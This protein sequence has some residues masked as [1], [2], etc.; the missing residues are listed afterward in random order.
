M[1]GAVLIVATHFGVGGVLDDIRMVRHPLVHTLLILEDITAWDASGG[2]LTKPAEP[3]VLEGSKLAIHGSP[4]TFVDAL[5]HG[6][7]VEVVVHLVGSTFVVLRA[8]AI[9]ED[10]VLGG[11]SCVSTLR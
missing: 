11:T 3:G 6:A 5:R 9:G 4:V 7:R 1:L 10:G 8:L 2:L